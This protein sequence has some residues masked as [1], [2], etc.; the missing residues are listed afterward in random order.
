MQQR[1]QDIS[2]AQK[3]IQVEDACHSVAPN[4][5]SQRQSS[6]TP[7][8][9]ACQQEERQQEDYPLRIA[10]NVIT[11]TRMGQSISIAR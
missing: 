11:A 2:K 10:D 1:Q 9:R 6:L 4:P 8:L 5:G 7:E 3:Q